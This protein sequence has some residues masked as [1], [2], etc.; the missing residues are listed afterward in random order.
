MRCGGCAIPTASS[1]PGKGYDLNL[2]SR[3]IS[4]LER[5][6][7]HLKVRVK[8]ITSWGDTRN[9]ADHGKFAEVTQTE[10]TLM[11]IGTRAFIDKHLP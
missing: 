7:A 10:L 3:T 4:A 9:K 1:R 8:Q 2:A 11:L 5:G 6:R